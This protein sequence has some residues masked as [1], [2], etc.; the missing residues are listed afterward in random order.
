MIRF[1]VCLSPVLTFSPCLKIRCPMAFSDLHCPF[2]AD[3]RYSRKKKVALM[4]SLLLFHGIALATDIEITSNDCNFEVR[5]DRD[6][7]VLDVSKL[8]SVE[9]SISSWEIELPK[10]KLKLPLE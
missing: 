1:P 7:T 5:K 10:D 9:N 3:I 8:I 4:L 2:F 6:A